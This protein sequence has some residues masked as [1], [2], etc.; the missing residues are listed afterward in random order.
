MSLHRVL[1]GLLSALLLAACGSGAGEPPADLVL[2]GGRVYT[3]AWGEPGL[4]GAPAADAP[5]DAEGWRPD[6]EALAVR[7]GVLVAV[8]DDAGIA[9][10]IGPQTRVVELEG[11]TVLPGMIDSHAH[12]AS[13]GELLS[14]VSLLGVAT[15]EEAVA[16]IAAAA[17][18]TP[19]GEWIVAWGFDEAVWADRLPDNR[20]LSGR[21]PEHPVHAV[22][23]HGF[24]TWENALSLELAGIT[25]ATEAPPGGVI[26]LNAAGRPTGILRD[27]AS[28]L[29][30][31]V[32]PPP[33]LEERIESARHGLLAMAELGYTAIHDAGVRREVLDAYT[34]LADR[35]RLPI[36][37]YAM[38]SIADEPL[39]RDWIARGPLSE[40]ANGLTVRSVKAYYDASLGARG[41]RLLEDY[42]DRPGHR[43][44]SGSDYGFDRGLAAEAMGAG[45]QIAIHAIGD[46]GNRETLDF[47]EGVYAESPGTRGNRNRIEHAQIVHPDDRS[48]FGRLDVIASMEPPHAVEDMAWA[49]DRLGPVR[50]RHGYA[51]RS[52]RRAGARLAFNSDMSGSDP[53]IFYG[54]HAAITRRDK[55]RSPPEGWFPEEA[56]TPEEA[57]RAYSLWNAYAGFAEGETGTLEVGKRA[58]VTVVDVDP[59]TLGETAPRQLLAGR[60]LMT[61][62]G[63]RVVFEAGVTE[64]VAGTLYSNPL[65]PAAGDVSDNEQVRNRGEGKDAWWNALPRA[66][67]SEFRRVEQSQDW[68][69]VYEVRPGVLAIYEPGQFEEVISYL[70]VGTDSALLFD[71][72]LGVADMRRLA[73]ELTDLEVLVLNSHTHYD[74]VG[75]NHAFETIYGTDLDYTREHER[76][77]PHEEVA[78]FVG[79]GWIWKKTPASFSPESYVSRPFGVTDR[80]E[81]GQV[82]DLGGVEL[83]IL[84]TPGHA[85]DA[86][87]LLDR[88]RRL[89][90]TGDTLYPATLYAHLPGSTFEDYGRTADRLAALADSVDVVLP[91]H[92]EPT[93]RAGDLVAFGGAFRAMERGD[94]PFVL[95]DGNREY[96]FD[97]FSILVPDPPPWAAD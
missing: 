25:G 33:T 39:M 63:G 85:P 81:N 83:E 41:A 60:V 18:E 84:L 19:A 46:A 38:L 31:A 6:A 73:R 1:A 92:N 69:E 95:T 68:F 96:S 90:F 16:R 93:M 40:P 64:P 10:F 77:R 36:R 5:Y 65:A 66:A 34:A 28:E 8:G 58:D 56:L 97:R 7:D 54:L 21:I 57:L 35:G 70:I 80:V 44:V 94:I 48:R 13:Y 9:S 78:E 75:G 47:L 53:N 15:E 51:W 79:A 89:L 61:V 88:T 86:L 71:T 76:G 17:A 62:V 87:C 82:L 50:V 3:L 37:V 45:F 22:S 52:L 24:V 27:N 11:A 23:L 59:L 32:I 20:L 14:R 67:W 43:G 26:E 72:G 42:E 74:H 12:V 2:R 29:Y 55:G 91:A 30:D 49:E 4:D